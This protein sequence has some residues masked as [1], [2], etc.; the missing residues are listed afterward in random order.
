MFDMMVGEC[1]AEDLLHPEEHPLYMTKSAQSILN[2]FLETDPRLRLGARGDTRSILMHPF[3]KAVNWEAVL[4]KR[5]T[6]PV[7]HRILELLSVDADDLGRSCSFKNRTCEAILE[8]P[9]PQPLA[10]KCPT[11][12]RGASIDADETGS[13]SPFESANDG[14]VVEEPAHKPQT[15]DRGAISDADETGSDSPFESANDG[16]AME[17]PAHKP[18]PMD[19]RASGDAGETG[20]DSPFENANDGAVMEEPAHK[21]QT[22][23]GG[24]IGEI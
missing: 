4:Q 18:Q 15:M 2:M 24:A 13:D 3:F 21:Q 5:V 14:A 10:V 16:A 23:D 12:V 19:R 1:P 11:M 20:S 17:E 8:Q 6:P 9:P 7:K 22:M